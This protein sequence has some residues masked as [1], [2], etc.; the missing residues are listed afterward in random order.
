MTEATL[1][2][3]RYDKNINLIQSQNA[4]R[5]QSDIIKDS[6]ATRQVSGI[7]NN[8]SSVQNY[9][10]KANHSFDSIQFIEGITTHK[11]GKAVS[12]INSSNL[13]AIQVNPTLVD[14]VLSVH[15]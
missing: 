1:S 3:E 14:S 10:L 5:A 11:K 12:S 7:M 2:E 15:S 8:L 6:Q 4:E 9:T 13:E